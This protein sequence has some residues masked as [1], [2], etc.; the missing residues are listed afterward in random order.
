MAGREVDEPDAPIETSLDQILAYIRSHWE[1]V[2]ER[3]RAE[4]DSYLECK[5][6]TSHLHRCPHILDCSLQVCLMVC[7]CVSMQE[8]QCVSSRLS[9]EEE[10]VEAL[11]AECNDTGCKIQSL[12]AETE[13]IRALVSHSQ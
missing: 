4:T 5:V 7:V 1:K 8:A 9:P 11:K 12:Q 3:N 13:S 6:R 10:Q 2:T